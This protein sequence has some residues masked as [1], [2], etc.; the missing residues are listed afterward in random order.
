V[1]RVWKMTAIR[2]KDAALGRSEAFLLEAQRLSSTGS[3][4]WRLPFD[5]FAWSDQ[6]YRIFEVDEGVDLTFPLIDSRVHPDDQRSMREMRDR[7]CSD[8]GDIDCEFRLLMPD[9]SV[10]HLRMVARGS[11][12]E[13]GSLEY[14]GAIQDVTQRRVAE[15]ALSKARSELLHV[16]RVMSLGALTA[17]IAHEVNQPLS[18]IITNATTCLRMLAADPPNVEGARAT[19]RRTL[20]DGTRAS[21]VIAR[22][23][24]LFAKKE[25]RL[26]PLDLNE[27][28]REVIALVRDELQ[29]N[30]VM[31]RVEL[32]DDLP[33]VH[34]DRV[35]LQQVVLNLLHNASEAMAGVGSRPRRVEVRT[36]RHEYDRVRLSV[37]DS[38]PGVEPHLMARL[39]EPFCS[40]KANG[41]GIGLFVCRSIIEHHRGS[42]DVMPN[43]GPGVTFS[44]SVPAV[45]ASH[46][47]VVA[48][49]QGVTYP[50]IQL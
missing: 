4:C 46:S 1:R 21:T 13:G 40:T 8:G 37:E 31:L 42:L 26:V 24:A 29:R 48:G 30:K 34:G 2:F 7:A 19:A 11:R 5:E 45:L 22:L 41:M 39:F 43:E 50:M 3:F 9:C 44:F 28:T 20:R 36:E 47:G 14:I 15:E 32:A 10:K 12:D 18:G 35:Q 16:T 38:G 25:T 49:G 33:R 17:S 6:L 23:R 27:A